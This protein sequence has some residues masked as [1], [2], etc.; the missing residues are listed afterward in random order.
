MLVAL[1]IGSAGC[2]LRPAKT[3]GP[4]ES[5]QHVRVSVVDVD[6]DDDLDEGDVEITPRLSV[7][8]KV[9]NPTRQP[10][11]LTPDKLS[12]L[13]GGKTPSP[14]E[15]DEAVT[16][17][18]GESKVIPLRFNE[19]NGCEKGFEL[20]FDDAIVLGT[21]PLQLASLRFTD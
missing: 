15:G 1:S 4:L 20:A 5:A 21:A 3:N 16:V 8:L 9:E 6:C 19:I 17:G 2:Y 11:E 13:S 12:L 18:A 7:R 14:A 10:A